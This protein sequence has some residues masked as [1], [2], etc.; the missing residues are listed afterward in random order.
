MRIANAICCTW[1]RIAVARFGNHTT[2][3]FVEEYVAHIQPAN[4]L[5]FG[6]FVKGCMV[7]AAELRSLA[8]CWCRDAEAAFSVARPW[9]RRSIGTALMAR[10]LAA[11][12]KLAIAHVHV[13]CD[14]INR[15]MQ[16]VA[17]KFAA[18]L[19]FEE[20]DGCADIALI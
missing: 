9:Q 18:R 7:G 5:V 17:E 8:T 11:A 13:S 4:T 1:T 10:V 16:R 15:G 3:R 14:P 12:H 6:C 2:E 19:R 20:G